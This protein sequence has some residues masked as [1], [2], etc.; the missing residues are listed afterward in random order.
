MGHYKAVARLDGDGWEVTIDGVGRLRAGD[1]VEARKKAL[2]LI[3]RERSDLEPDL[4]IVPDVD[5]HRS[6]PS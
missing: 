6:P 3:A 5:G 2:R 4:E 1:L